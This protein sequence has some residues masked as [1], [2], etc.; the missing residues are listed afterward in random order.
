[1]ERERI[2]ALMR[3]AMAEA[4]VAV[5]EGN[6]PFGALLVNEQGE[7]VARAHNTE[8]TDMD[9]TAHAETNLVRQACQAL[10]TRDLSGYH[11][12]CNAESCSM[13]FSAAIKAGIRDYYV[14]AP[15]EPH[16][17]PYVTM[18]EIAA[19]SQRPLNI[20]SNVLEEEC[21]RQIREA[22]EKAQD[23]RGEGE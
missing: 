14:G 16:M 13:C 2:E 15:S 11:L 21:A 12:F 18:D 1:M 5:E 8:V 20:T 9:P 19:K 6:N 3:E 4:A 10:G 23:A 7:V 22:R 17:D